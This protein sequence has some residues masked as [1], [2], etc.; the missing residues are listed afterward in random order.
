MKNELYSCLKMLESLYNRTINAHNIGRW[1]VA[2]YLNGE[3]IRIRNLLKKHLDE[4]KFDFVPSIE[5][6]SFSNYY[7]PYDLEKAQKACVLSVAIACDIAISFLKSLEM[8]LDKELARQKTEFKLKEKELEFKENEVKH[9]GKLLS[10]SLEAIKEFP[11]LQRSK[12]MEE[13]K[14]S[15]REIEKNT[16]FKSKSQNN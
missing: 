14:K 16:N 2:I 12:I 8:S 7:R 11:E 1:E 10:K 15:H 13:I 5:K 9:M 4:E 6:A 3:Y